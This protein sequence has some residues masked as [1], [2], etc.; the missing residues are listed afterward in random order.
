LS[1]LS[2]SC[3]PRRKLSLRRLRINSNKLRPNSRLLSRRKLNLMT[4]TLRS[5]QSKRRCKPM[6]TNSREKWIKL[7]S[8]SIL[9]L[10][11]RSDGLK[12]HVNLQHRRLDWL[13]MLQKPV[14]SFHT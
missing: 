5:R 14:H 6:Q 12:V 7:P 1:S 10:T 2:Y 13:V 9:L 8:L 4:C 11:T 3:L